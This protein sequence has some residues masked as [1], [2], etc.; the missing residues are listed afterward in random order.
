MHLQVITFAYVYVYAW[1]KIHI[2]IGTTIYV[3]PS[4]MINGLSMVMQYVT[5]WVKTS[6]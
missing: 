4:T 6:I 2:Q 1:V 3:E 5:S